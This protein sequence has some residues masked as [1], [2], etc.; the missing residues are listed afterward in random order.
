MSM[1]VYNQLQFNISDETK[2]YKQYLDRNIVSN[3]I[4]LYKTCFKDIYTNSINISK[5]IDLEELT[6]F[7]KDNN[8]KSICNLIETNKNN[9]STMSFLLNSI[10][11]KD[12]DILQTEISYDELVKIINIYVDSYEKFWL[13]YDKYVKLLINDYVKEFISRLKAKINS[14]SFK[15]CGILSPISNLEFVE[16][17]VE[18]YMRK[19]SH[20]VIS[21][22]N[23]FYTQDKLINFVNKIN[24]K[25]N[26]LSSY[27]KLLSNINTIKRYLAYTKPIV[28]NIQQDSSKK[29]YKL[30]YEELRNIMFYVYTATHPVSPISYE[31]DGG[32][33]ISVKNQLFSVP[34]LIEYDITCAN[35]I[36]YIPLLLG[37][38]YKNK[39]Y[40]ICINHDGLNSD[41]SIKDLIYL[42]KE[43]IDVVKC[44]MSN[45]IELN[46]F[47]RNE[48]YSVLD[49]YMK[50]DCEESSS[51]ENIYSTALKVFKTKK[52]QLFKLKYQ[53]VL[54]NKYDYHRQ[55][56]W[57]SFYVDL[58]N[59]VI[60]IV[61]SCLI[62]DYKNGLIKK[63]LETYLKNEAYHTM[64]KTLKKYIEQDI[65]R[66]GLRFELIAKIDR[67]E[68][69]NS[70][71]YSNRTNYIS[72]IKVLGFVTYIISELLAHNLYGSKNHT[73]SDI[74]GLGIITS[75]KDSNNIN[76]SL[77]ELINLD[78]NSPQERDITYR[79]YFSYEYRL[80]NSPYFIYDNG[81][82][83]STAIRYPLMNIIYKH[84]TKNYIVSVI[85][86]VYDKVLK[87]IIKTNKERYFDKDQLS[88]TFKDLSTQIKFYTSKSNFEYSYY[89]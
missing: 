58:Y 82:D 66:F 51:I 33:V 10:L 29:Y 20:G 45:A 44:N 86:T 4:Y 65:N 55:Y 43:N 40:K 7:F 19:K 24:N 57:D 59:K 23:A 32:S 2:L 89:N 84:I 70:F 77:D 9:D 61:W 1:D 73:S 47:G 18:A 72:N 25:T 79:C 83:L 52:K 31:Y 76:L 68:Y 74:L 87:N 21:A 27:S 30:N 17:K 35:T 81:S 48:K 54:N 64:Q 38:E 12:I 26:K 69:F 34:I 42:S 37:I 15:V 62:L 6:K 85:N 3:H 28:T 63:E 49:N 14:N 39:L 88:K 75:I 78:P 36:P 13:E 8:C 16:D 46:F 71:I 53:N 56:N 50:T 80:D 67:G 5:D 11:Y 60:D 41:S 22:Y